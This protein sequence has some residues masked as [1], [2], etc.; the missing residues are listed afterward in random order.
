[1][2]WTSIFHSDH[3][4]LLQ[5]AHPLLM[6]LRVRPESANIVTHWPLFW[7]PTTL[8]KW[9]NISAVLVRY[10]QVSVTRTATNKT[11]Y[12]LWSMAWYSLW[13]N[14]DLSRTPHPRLAAVN[15]KPV[16]QS[17]D[18]KGIQPVKRWVLVCWWWF[19]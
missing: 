16:L 12:M 3:W 2:S 6:L 15:I 5:A 9:A 10:A 1:M 18:T 13:Q 11:C 7:Q 4:N 14:F 8:T 19:D 17:L